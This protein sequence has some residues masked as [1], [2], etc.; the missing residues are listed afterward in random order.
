MIKNGSKGSGEE[1]SIILNIQEG[2]RQSNL[3]LCYDDAISNR[4]RPPCS[5]RP[6][7]KLAVVADRVRT[8]CAK[9]S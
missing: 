2:S 8:P 9:G 1:A 7:N 5:W 4:M 3:S 6:V